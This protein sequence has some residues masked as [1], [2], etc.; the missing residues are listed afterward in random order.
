MTKNST[1]SGGGSRNWGDAA[2]DGLWPGLA[3]G[4]VMIV[5]LIVAGLLMGEEPLAV[6]GYF[7]PDEGLPAVAGL[8]THLAVSAVHGMVFGLLTAVFSR[9]RPSVVPWWAV[10][11]IYGLLLWLMA[12]LV[13]IP[14]GLS[15]L[16]EIGTFHF[17]VGHLMFGVVMGWMVG[18]ARG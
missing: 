2:V 16:G 7:R 3:G 4:L 14:S 17:L 12:A 18:R 6:L 1:I 11:A 13:I 10:G 15:E 8:G 9:F 5:Y